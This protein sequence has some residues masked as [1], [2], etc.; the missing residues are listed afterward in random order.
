MQPIIYDVAVSADGFIASPD[1]DFSLFPTD[2]DVVADYMARVQSYGTVIMGRA[3][4]EVIYAYGLEPGTNPYPHADTYVV[5]DQIELP[6]LSDVTR[7]ASQDA[8]AIR[9]IAA[10]STKPVYLAGGGVF[11][12]WMLRQGLIDLLRLKRAPL[13]LGAGIRLFGEDHEPITTAPKSAKLYP[14]GVLYQ[15]IHLN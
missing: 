15:E 9:S 13:I 11:A 10:N 6:Q 8:S 2:E 1:G 3:T 4:Y 14:G 12:G 5:S 7:I